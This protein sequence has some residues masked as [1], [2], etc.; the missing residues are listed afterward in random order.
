MTYIFDLDGTVLK[1]HT[2]EWIEGAKEHILDLHSKGHRIIFIT[3]RSPGNSKSEWSIENA[4][5]I[6]K[7][8]DIEYDVLYDVPSPRFLIDDCKPTAIH[9]KRNEK[10]N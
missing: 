1:Y 5:K 6:L 10:W 9:R 4:E 7:T 3:M 2:N 8:L